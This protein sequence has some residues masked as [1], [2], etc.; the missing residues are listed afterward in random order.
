MNHDGP[1]ERTD[2]T[3]GYTTNN[4]HFTIGIGYC[5]PLEEFSETTIECLWGG[6]RDRYGAYMTPYREAA[7]AGKFHDGGHASAG[8][9]CDCYKQYLLDFHLKF[10]PEVS[11]PKH[12]DKCQVD[13]C[14]VFTSG[15]GECGIG[16]SDH[17]HLCADHRNRQAVEPMIKVGESWH[18]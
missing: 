17:W 14:E 10:F 9:A 7:A 5:R 3:W 18:S 12:L 2:G 6:D 4:S 1:R 13:G 11:D 15:H 16:F 8:E